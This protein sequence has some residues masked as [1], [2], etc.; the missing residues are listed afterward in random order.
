MAPPSNRLS[1][2]LEEGHSQGWTI[3]FVWQAQGAVI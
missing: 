2:Q 3:S 1:R